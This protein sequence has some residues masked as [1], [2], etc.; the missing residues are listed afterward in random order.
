M[1]HQLQSK[2]RDMINR[3]LT[4]INKQNYRE[5]ERER[6]RERACSDV[7]HEGQPKDTFCSQREWGSRLLAANHTD[8]LPI[9]SDNNSPP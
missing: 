9:V 2:S 1:S 7:D 8:S 5:I 6:E 3:M 4:F